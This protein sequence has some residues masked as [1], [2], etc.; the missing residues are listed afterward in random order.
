MTA[1]QPWPQLKLSP[2]ARKCQASPEEP[3]VT[4]IL[5]DTFITDSY[6]D[7]HPLPRH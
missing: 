3:N 1:S 7:V 5:R 4:N 6:P 2:A